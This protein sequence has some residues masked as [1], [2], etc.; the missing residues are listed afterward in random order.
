MFWETS[1]IPLLSLHFLLH[2]CRRNGLG[3]YQELVTLPHILSSTFVIDVIHGFLVCSSSCPL[4]FSFY[5]GI[6]RD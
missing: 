4:S 1:Y 5:K 2:S 3:Y 6:L